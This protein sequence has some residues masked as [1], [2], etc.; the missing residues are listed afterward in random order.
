ML[1]CAHVIV[2]P[3]DSRTAVLRRG[4]RKGFIGTIPVGG[5]HTPSSIVGASLLWK[6]AQKNAKKKHTSDVINS[7][8]PYRSPVLTGKVWDPW[9]VASR[10]TSRHHFIIVI[11]SNRVPAIN[12]KFLFM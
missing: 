12:R 1:W 8:I 2:T 9:K 10:I 11:T 3:D 6:K 5:Q 7:I 4:T